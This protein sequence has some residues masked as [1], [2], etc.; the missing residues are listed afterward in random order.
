MRAL[1][2]VVMCVGLLGCDKKVKQVSKPTAGKL[3][4]KSLAQKEFVSS[5]SEEKKNDCIVMDDGQ[6]IVFSSVPIQLN[7][8]VKKSEEVYLSEYKRVMKAVS[9]WKRANPEV[10]V[11]IA[12]SER[13]GHFESH[14]SEATP[15]TVRAV[16]LRD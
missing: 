10:K 4:A 16:L 5:V 15:Y 6:L 2:F 11:S 12:V 7:Y 8:S 1:L 3:E 9:A 14:N 13:S